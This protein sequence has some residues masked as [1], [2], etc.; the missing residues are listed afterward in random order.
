MLAKEILLAK[1]TPFKPI[2]VQMNKK[3]KVTVLVQEIKTV[4]SGEK[5]S[6]GEHAR[7]KTFR[8]LKHVVSICDAYDFRVCEFF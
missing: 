6:T 3:K 8:I 1:R 4:V 7:S 5:K 2:Q